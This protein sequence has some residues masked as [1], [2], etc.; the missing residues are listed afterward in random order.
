MGFAGL[1]DELLVDL[2]VNLFVLLLTPEL[3]AEGG[4]GQLEAG[5]ETLFGNT[6]GLFQT[7]FL[8]V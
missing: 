5:T 2:N 8:S 3:S 4:D 7:P 6:A 1:I